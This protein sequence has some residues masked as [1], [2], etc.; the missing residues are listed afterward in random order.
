MRSYDEEGCLTVRT[1]RHSTDSLGKPVLCVPVCS[2][3]RSTVF[4]S[5]A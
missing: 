4:Q 2:A 5:T 1:H 3:T